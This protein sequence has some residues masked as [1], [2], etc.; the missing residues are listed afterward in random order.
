MI[1]DN[2]FF[3]Y[4]Y[5]TCLVPIQLVKIVS[6]WTNREFSANIVAGKGFSIINKIKRKEQMKVFIPLQIDIYLLFS[7][8]LQG[9][10]EGNQEPIH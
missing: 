10:W 6:N 8:S 5:S 3:F 9:G 1:C 4:T 7:Y 2:N